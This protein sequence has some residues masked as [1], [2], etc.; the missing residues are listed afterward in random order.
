MNLLTS[1]A[2]VIVRRAGYALP[3]ENKALKTSRAGN[4]PF[5]QLLG[6]LGQTSPIQMP[7]PP[8]PPSDTT[9]LNAQQAYHEALLRYNQQFQT[10]HTRIVQLFMQRFQQMQQTITTMQQTQ[11]K[12]SVP[13]L[14]SNLAGSSNIG[15]ILEGATDILE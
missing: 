5:G 1:I 7:T 10:Y 2:Q 4:N 13:S 8:T 3:S 15:G 12:N 9:D 11:S 6:G 14:Q